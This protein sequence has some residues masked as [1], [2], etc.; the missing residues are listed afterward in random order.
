VSQFLGAFKQFID[1]EVF[2]RVLALEK[3]VS[4]GYG[5]HCGNYGG[6]GVSGLNQLEMNEAKYLGSTGK[7]SG[8]KGA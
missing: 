7:G 4:E 6:G 3:F 1:Q 2:A 8:W 5:R